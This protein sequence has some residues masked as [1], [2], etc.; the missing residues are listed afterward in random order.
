MT[1]ILSYII[2][3]IQLFR[4]ELTIMMITYD[5]D[6][7]WSCKLI[8]MI[9]MLFFILIMMIVFIYLWNIVVNIQLFEMASQ[10]ALM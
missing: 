6:N 7:I 8:I 5:M 4:I 2:Y 9:I 3:Y 10:P 1:Y